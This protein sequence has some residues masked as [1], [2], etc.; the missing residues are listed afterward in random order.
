MPHRADR[1]V[2]TGMGLVAPNGIGVEVFWESLLRG[3][4]GI[5][6]I[7]LFDARRHPCRVAGEVKGFSP[8][9]HIGEGINARRMAR[10][11]QL[12]M[13]AT[14][15]AVD[16]AGIICNG[17]PPRHS[18]PLLLGASS[19]AIDVIEPAMRKMFSKGPTR[20]PSHIVHASHPQ[21]AASVIGE[22]L[23]F[24]GQASTISSACA[25]GLEAVAGARQMVRDGRA[26][27]AV[28]GGTDAPVTAFTF[29]CFSKACLVPPTNGQ[30]GKAGR[31]FDLNRKAGVI[32]EGAGVVVLETPEHARARQATPIL[33]ITGFA[34]SS[35]MEADEPGTG[36]SRTMRDA[37]ANAGRHVQDVDFV[38]AHGPGHPVLDKV[39]TDAI[40]RVLS[41]HAYRIPVT[42]IKGAVGNPLAAAGV[43]QLIACALT[44]RDDVIPPTVNLETPDPECD[45][46]YVP[47]TARRA[48]VNCALINSHGL[49]GGNSTMV[50]ERV[51]QT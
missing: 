27:L 44:I 10:Q 13:A 40:K 37:L 5:G 12:A 2:V 36:L 17:V 23:G 51:S 48:R 7:T 35:D 3:E 25:A 38:S 32:S 9:A 8:A 11:T 1:V 16:D 43:M 30:P 45:L 50:V 39:E 20:V 14:L 33:E 21:Q 28:A 41:D 6:P 47:G 24:V 29:A 49:G 42:S 4:T 26:E 19:N 46:D 15:M 22:H 31:P 34:S 18:T